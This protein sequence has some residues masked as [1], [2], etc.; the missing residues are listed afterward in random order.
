MV[1]RTNGLLALAPPYS[2]LQR[3]GGFDFGI[4]HLRRVARRIPNQ[5]V[6]AYDTGLSP[7]V[8]TPDLH[9][10]GASAA[11]HPQRGAA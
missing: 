9:S 3:G 1:V 6:R 5:R 10:A 4:A 2:G 8:C 11:H 7:R